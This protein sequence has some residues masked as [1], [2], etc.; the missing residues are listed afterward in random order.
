MRSGETA[1]AKQIMGEFDEFL[2]PRHR[3]R[4]SRKA[5]KYT[6]LGPFLRARRG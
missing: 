1:R 6:L 2:L 4:L 5:L 3:R